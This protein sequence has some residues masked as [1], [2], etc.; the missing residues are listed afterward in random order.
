MSDSLYE[1]ERKRLSK[2]TRAGRFEELLDFPCAHSFKVIGEPRGMVARLR[3]V[4]K[5]H[6]HPDAL[7]VE[8]RSKKGNWLAVTVEVTVQSGKELD[9]IYTDLEQ[10]P[11]VRY[12][13]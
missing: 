7:L 10:L 6:E 4:L 2:L 11:G 9:A 1:M 13:L 12:L 3:Q 8:R 5:R